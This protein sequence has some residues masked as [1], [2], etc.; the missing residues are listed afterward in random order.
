MYS[1][2]TYILKKKKKYNVLSELVRYFR[3]D[4]VSL[5]EE[6]SIVDSALVFQKVE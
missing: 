5:Y 2:E 6:F 4:D 1:V 3:S